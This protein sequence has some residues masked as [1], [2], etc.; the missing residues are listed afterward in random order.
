LAALARSQKRFGFVEMEWRANRRVVCTLGVHRGIEMGSNLYRVDR[1][2][3]SRRNGLRHW[4]A[5]EKIGCFA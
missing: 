1:R 4:P 2:S 3:R 5:P